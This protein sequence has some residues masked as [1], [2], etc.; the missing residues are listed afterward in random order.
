M[1]NLLVTILVAAIVLGLVFYV[2]TLLPL[3]AP[4]GLIA[5]VA[6]LIIVILVF[7]YML[8]PVLAHGPHV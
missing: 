2:I 8:V 1:I 4:F 5:R 3:P 7:A 6:F